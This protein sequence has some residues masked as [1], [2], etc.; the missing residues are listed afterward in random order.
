MS[1]ARGTPARNIHMTEQ[2]YPQ[3]L[4]EEATIAKLVNRAYRGMARYG[5]GDF[6]VM[7][8]AI[9][10]YHKACPKLAKAIAESLHR[11]NSQVLNCLIP[12]P[13]DMRHG[14]LAFQRWTMYLEM[15]AGILPF[16]S[17]ELYGSSNVSRMDSCPH[18]HTTQWWTTISAL[19]AGKEICL[20]SGSERSLTETK[21]LGSPGAPSGIVHVPCKPRDNFSQFDELYHKVLE[22]DREVVILSAG[23]TT[24]PLVHRLVAAGHLAYDMGHLGLWFN[25]GKPIPL[26]DC[27]R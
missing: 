7:R 9:D 22:A 4:T 18:L 21:L 26:P 1:K 5:D 17:G 14:N 13:S 12:P 27:I 15:N 8:G 2:D 3:V 19:W 25:Q 11:G 23:L 6:N 16:L 20:V 10:R 24:R